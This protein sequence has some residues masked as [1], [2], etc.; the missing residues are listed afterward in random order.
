M[1][2]HVRTVTLRSRNPAPQAVP[3]PLAAALAA[4]L[5]LCA[6][7]AR[8]ADPLQTAQAA[9]AA[10]REATRLTGEAYEQQRRG[11]LNDA[12]KLY[13]QAAELDP[14]PKRFRNLAVPLEQAGRLVE[15]LAAYR[16][17]QRDAQGE[18]PQNQKDVD[19]RVAALLL[20][21]GTLTVTLPSDPEAEVGLR[22]PA[23]EASPPTDLRGALAAGSADTHPRCLK[24][25]ALR[26]LCQPGPVTAQ[27]LLGGQVVATRTVQV[28]AQAQSEL[29]FSTRAL[30]RIESNRGQPRLLL[31]KTPLVLTPPIRLPVTLPL[32]LG[33][34]V[35]YG[36]D[37][38]EQVEQP[39]TVSEGQRAAQ[40][41]R[42]EF[43]PS[44]RWIWGVV[45]GGA[46]VVGAV[47]LG[48]AFGLPPRPGGAD[49]IVTQGP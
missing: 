47:A 48:L 25:D 11:A 13:Q 8:A 10:A 14:L 40:V 49:V 26:Y 27:L 45:A 46:V 19:E 7:P 17:F 41:V 44:R 42:L 3:G 6:S 18:L 24:D 9:Q 16:R 34:H 1:R 21:L 38:R 4:L 35:L 15:A 30:V 37:G 32:L 2:Y 31:D 29:R 12:I 33:R 39:F 43:R 23:A 28:Q 22:V 5:S 20:R 36:Q